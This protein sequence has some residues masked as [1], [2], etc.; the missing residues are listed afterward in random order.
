MLFVSGPR[1][2]NWIPPTIN[3][4]RLLETTNTTL[5][6]PWGAE[7]AAAPNFIISELSRAARWL[8]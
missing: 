7:G 5:W 3:L 1:I 4:A 6:E 8:P 2:I